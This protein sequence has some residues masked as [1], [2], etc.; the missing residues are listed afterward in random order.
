MWLFGGIARKFLK[1]SNEHKRKQ[2]NMKRNETNKWVDCSVRSG[3]Y[4]PNAPPASF[5]LFFDPPSFFL[6]IF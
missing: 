3:K 2:T 6:S 1:N 4:P 5:V